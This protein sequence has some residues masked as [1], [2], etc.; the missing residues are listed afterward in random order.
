MPIGPEVARN[1]SLR[2]IQARALAEERSG[3]PHRA[4]EILAPMTDPERDV[5]PADRFR[6]IAELVRMAIACGELDAARAATKLAI[7]DAEREPL[8]V[9]IAAASACRG[10]LDADPALL[11]A[12]AEE[13][14]A[15]R[16]NLDR[17]MAL[18]NAA[19]LLG[20]R[21]DVA[22]ARAALAAALDEYATL[23]A[24][25]D[26]TRAE[27]RMRPLG[28][29]RGQRGRRGRPSAGWAA[30]TPT[31]LRVA[32]FVADG[33]S[34]PDIARELYLSRRTVETH[35]SHILT[36][37]DARSRAEIAG[38]VAEHRGA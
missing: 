4:F 8:P 30:L 27:A 31:E 1:H 17:G 19:V 13:F 5:D 34:N 28:I 7:Q 3:W 36:K 35:V 12:A 18:E 2:L 16:R 21:G 37:L 9:R 10:L 26:M 29:R 6:W 20:A 24:T 33:L 23:A 11:M 22:P 32:F 15:G 38:V 14:R 25:W